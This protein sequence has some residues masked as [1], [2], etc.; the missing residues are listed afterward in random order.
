[1]QK[2]IALLF[3]LGACSKINIGTR[4]PSLADIRESTYQVRVRIV[5]DVSSLIKEKSGDQK[6]NIMAEDILLNGEA[7]KAT[8]AEIVGVKG[9]PLGTFGATVEIGWVGTGWTVARTDGRSFAMT[10]GHV[11]ESKD[12]MEIA[13]FDWDT[14]RVMVVTL[15]IVSKTHTLVSY[16]GVS[17]PASVIRDED[18]DENF[19]GTDLCVLGARA[20]L[21]APIAIA[22]SDPQFGARA[23]VVGGPKGLWGGG[24]AVASDVKF[25]GRGTIFGVEPDGLA[26]NGEVA[27]GN[28]GSAVIYNGAAVGV[29][30]L[31]ATRFPSLVH[32]VPH[33]SMREFL[34]KALHK[35]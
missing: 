32:A 8:S 22:N 14:F 13:V 21:G 18:L 27:P 20:D 2:I 1:M 26:F 5:L 29:I 30:S 34:R 25:G 3:V 31:G 4:E 17:V 9:Q 7:H 33:E 23:E 6:K 16:D 11:C 35:N 19:N 15:P 10:A 24:I 12:T 28:S